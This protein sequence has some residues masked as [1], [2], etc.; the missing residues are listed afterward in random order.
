VPPGSLQA[1][2]DPL[3]RLIAAAL[4]FRAGKASPEMITLAADTASAQGW[5][6]PLLA[7]LKVQALRAER[8]GAADE[9]QR[10]R[11]RIEL[12]QGGQ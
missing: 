8:V 5:R 3:S 11:R 6:R 4:L 2:D 10:L 9:A 1:I 12:V 7:W